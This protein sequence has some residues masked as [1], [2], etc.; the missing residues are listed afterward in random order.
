MPSKS[1]SPTARPCQLCGHAPLAEFSV[2]ARVTFWHCPKCGLYQDGPQASDAC[3]EDE[4]YHASY[5]AQSGRKLHTAKTRLNRLAPLVTAECPRLLD[6]GCGIGVVM[7]A[8]EARGW[9]AIGVDISQRIVNQCRAQGLQAERVPDWNL[10]FDDESFDVVTAWSVIEH[11]ADVRHVLREW[12]RVLRPGGV[13]AMDTSDAACLKVRLLGKRY[14]GIWVPGHTYTFTRPTLRAFCRQAGFV[15]LRQPLVGRPRGM[16]LGELAL[17]AAY[18]VQ[19][20]L[21]DLLRI[22]KAFQLF[23]RK[24]AAAAAE[25]FVICR[26]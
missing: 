9:E 6:V 21:R 18:Q 17:A 15:E 24:P 19:Y 7:Q 3:H 11:V 2:P 14:R 5:V 20:D 13:L 8:A 16:S 1:P 4:Q 12:F 23:L 10:P 25:T 22:Q 26:R